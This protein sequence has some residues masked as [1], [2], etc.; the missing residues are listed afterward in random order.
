[1]ARVF[2]IEELSEALDG[3]IDSHAHTEHERNELKQLAFDLSFEVHAALKSAVRAVTPGRQQRTN[4][5]PMVRAAQNAFIRTLRRRAS[6][7]G[8]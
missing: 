6:K 1:M 3:V 2:G 7:M 8:K 5:D 4:L